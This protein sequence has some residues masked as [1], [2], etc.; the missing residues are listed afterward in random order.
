LKIFVNIVPKVFL[1]STRWL[2]IACVILLSKQYL[3]YIVF[4]RNFLGTKYN[5]IRMKNLTWVKVLEK[6]LL[7]E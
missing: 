3:Y 1:L 7:N 2:R 5:S 6:D 4:G